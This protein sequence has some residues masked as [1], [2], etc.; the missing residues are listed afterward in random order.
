MN[1]F[2]ATCSIGLGVCA[3]PL[4]ADVT[5]EDIAP[6]NVIVIAGVANVQQTLDR[7]DQTGLSGIWDE[8][9]V[10]ELLDKAGDEFHEDLDEALSRIGADREDLQPPTGSVGIAVYGAMDEELGT[11]Q[12]AFM[13]YG[14]WGEHAGRIDDLISAILDEGEREDALRWEESDLLG[15]TVRTIEWVDDDPDEVDE[16]DHFGEDFGQGPMADPFDDLGELHLVRDGDRFLLGSDIESLGDALERIDGRLGQNVGQRDDFQAVR[17]QLGESDA[18]FMFLTRDVQR[19]IAGNQDMMMLNMMIPMLEPVFGTV[20]G[21]GA[22]ARVRD[23]ETMIESSLSAY[24]PEGKKG[25]FSLIDAGG[26]REDVP[27]FAGL[28]T[29]GYWVTH[30]NFDRVVGVLDTV[31]QS[32]PMLA[33]EGEQMMAQIRPVLEEITA[34]LGPKIHGVTAIRE[35]IEADSAWS[36][37]AIEAHD[38][39]R[40]ENALAEFAP[41]FGLEPRDFL[42]YQIYEIPPEMMG[43]MGGGPGMG[44]PGPQ[45]G[46]SVGIGSGFVFVGESTPVENTLRTVGD[47]D[48]EGI[49]GEPGFQR[50][51]SV[52]GEDDLLAWGYDDIVKQWEHSV[53]H[54]EAQFGEMIDNIAEDEPGLADEMRELDSELDDFQELLSELLPKYF[55]PMVWSWRS[56]DDGFVGKFHYLQP[57]MRD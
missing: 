48:G 23:D 44:A 51:V 15:R 30:F 46:V 50:A 19:M 57:D 49:D 17:N 35:P 10:Q 34:S 42:G 6:D 32:N 18:Y 11:M 36:V 54:G 25:L 45:D 33:M 40:F 9:K 14:D 41:Q 3:S 55:G 52:L 13:L 24:L 21:I 29:A 12:P 16:F 22:A 4:A 7:I 5:I 31:I 8:P 47:R 2:I 27:A 43:G 28:D 39:Q 38:E 1:R 20:G 37:V 26:P 53:V 56:I